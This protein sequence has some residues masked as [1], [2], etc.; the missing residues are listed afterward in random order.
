MLCEHEH[1]Q[2]DDD[3]GAC[4]N[5]HGGRGNIS[6]AHQD[7][8]HRSGEHRSCETD[9]GVHRLTKENEARACQQGQ[10][11]KQQQHECFNGF[12]HRS[13]GFQW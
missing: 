5:D 8:E 10:A 1:E 4:I 3:R 7:V 12:N 2:E 9:S 11:C 6:R 13:V